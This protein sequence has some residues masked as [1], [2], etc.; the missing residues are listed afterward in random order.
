MGGY[1]AGEGIELTNFGHP[2]HV[3][4]RDK[5]QWLEYRHLP[6]HLQEVS[7]PF[8]ELGHLISGPMGLRGDQAILALQHLIDAKDCAVRAA[9]TQA[10]KLASSE[11][12][13]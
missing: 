11:D 10:D 12:R 2:D 13:P 8:C 9:K 6:E 3:A 4:V 7:K 5:L 1:T